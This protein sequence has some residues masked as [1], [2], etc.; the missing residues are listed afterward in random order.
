MQSEAAHEPRAEQ[1]L[2]MGLDPASVHVERR[3]LDRSAVATKNAADLSLLE[4][5]ITDFADG[6]ARADRVAIGR[7]V[8][9]FRDRGQFPAGRITRGLRRQRTVLTEHQAARPAFAV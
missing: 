7:W 2:D 9:A 6:Q 1:W 5:P 8:F 4:I 3:C